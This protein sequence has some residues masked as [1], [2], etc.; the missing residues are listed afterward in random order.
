VNCLPDPENPPDRDGL[1]GG[2]EEAF[3]L[4]FKFTT[5]LTKAITEMSISK[6]LF[7][8]KPTGFSS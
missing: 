6:Y 5:P 1:V 7:I 2:V 3:A 8:S 4:A